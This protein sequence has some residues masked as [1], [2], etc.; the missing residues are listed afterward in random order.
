[1]K[2]VFV[3]Q[4]TFQ[5]EYPN[6]D[7]LITL[8]TVKGELAGNIMQRFNPKMT[9]SKMNLMVQRRECERLFLHFLTF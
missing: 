1:M 2:G 6:F 7:P 9:A 4:A 5:N 3:L 8:F